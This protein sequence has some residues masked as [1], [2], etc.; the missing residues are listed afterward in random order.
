MSGAED[1]F[2]TPDDARRLA[3]R[4]GATASRWLIPGAGHPGSTRD[5]FTVQPDEYRARVLQ[6][7]EAV[8][9][10]S[11]PASAAPTTGS[12]VT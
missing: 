9:P 10:P 7:L 11:D 6:L 4:A 3:E 2:V 8:L 1:A 5:P 12:S